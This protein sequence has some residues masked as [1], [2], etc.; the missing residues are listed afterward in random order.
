MAEKLWHDDRPAVPLWICLL[1]IG[2]AY[3]FTPLAWV[4]DRFTRR[5]P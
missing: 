5:R 1:V 2:V 3:V 4:V